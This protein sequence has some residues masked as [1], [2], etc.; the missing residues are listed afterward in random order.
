MSDCERKKRI[1]HTLI[2]PCIPHRPFPCLKSSADTQK[3]T[4]FLWSLE[5]QV[6]RK[7]ED[8]FM[9]NSGVYAIVL[10]PPFKRK[11]GG[12]LLRQTALLL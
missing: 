12:C 9:L 3:Q 6:P 2:C 10:S 5:Y 8:D 11:K 1:P 4:Q 7:V